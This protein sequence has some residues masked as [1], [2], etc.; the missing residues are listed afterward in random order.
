MEAMT[1]RLPAFYRI[2]DKSRV[3][4][5]RSR[6]MLSSLAPGSMTREKTRPGTAISGLSERETNSL[7]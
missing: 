6:V 3:G 7:R 5:V 4:R 2:D 1:L